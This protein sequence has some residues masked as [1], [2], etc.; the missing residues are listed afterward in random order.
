[1][2]PDL[3]LDALA[4]DPAQARGLSRDERLKL[5]QRAGGLLEALRTADKQ[6]TLVSGAEKARPEG[7]LLS[8]EQIAS[9]FNVKASWVYE[10]ARLGKLPYVQLGRYRRFKLADVEAALA[11]GN[12]HD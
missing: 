1:M 4:L 10:W 11:Q 8:A 7:E 12:D 5:I 3:T 2:K 6:A 9:R